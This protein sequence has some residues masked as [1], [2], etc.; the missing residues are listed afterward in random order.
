MIKP[1]IVKQERPILSQKFNEPI[2][3]NIDSKRD[4]SSGEKDDGFFDKHQR[5]ELLEKLLSSELKNNMPGELSE[6][7]QLKRKKKKR[8]HL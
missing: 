4:I 7:Q 6:E 1:E 5:F 2:K 3:N 8:L